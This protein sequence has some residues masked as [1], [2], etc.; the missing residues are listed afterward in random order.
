MI[1]HQSAITKKMQTLSE[2]VLTALSLFF[3]FY[4]E[5]YESRGHQ[6]SEVY[7]GGSQSAHWL[8]PFTFSII[9]MKSILS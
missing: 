3:I 6:S 8:F 5:D 9:Q 4:L 7:S 2:R 1:K